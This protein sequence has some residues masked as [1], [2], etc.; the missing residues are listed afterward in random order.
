MAYDLRQI[1]QEILHSSEQVMLF[2]KH[3]LFFNLTVRHTPQGG[4]WSA[5]VRHKPHILISIYNT[6]YPGFI[7][8]LAKQC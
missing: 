4:N 3:E 6:H 1:G 2:M 8:G 7:P 5:D